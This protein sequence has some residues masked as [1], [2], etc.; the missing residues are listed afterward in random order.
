M[1]Q[2]RIREA[3][4]KGIHTNLDVRFRRTFI[5]CKRNWDEFF[6]YRALIDTS[7]VPSELKPYLPLFAAF[8]SKLGAKEMSYKVNL[9]KRDVYYFT[10]FW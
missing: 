7:A 2:F 6:Y 4:M 5:Q 1:N 9:N 10:A 8:L 3:K